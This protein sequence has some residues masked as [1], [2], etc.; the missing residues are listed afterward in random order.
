VGF[1]LYK[2][3]CHY[4]VSWL[5]RMFFKNYVSSVI[6]LDSLEKIGDNLALGLGS[7]NDD[8]INKTTLNP[9]YAHHSW[10]G[11]CPGIILSL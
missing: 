4:D 8:D 9:T 6:E 7:G 3:C 10:E 1:K 2:I 5:K 11:K